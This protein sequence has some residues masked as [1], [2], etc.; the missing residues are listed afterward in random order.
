[1]ALIA[2]HRNAAIIPVVTV[3][4]GTSF[5]FTHLL[6]SEVRSCVEVEVAVLSFPS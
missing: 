2:A 3:A 5:P 4:L 1:M 6:G